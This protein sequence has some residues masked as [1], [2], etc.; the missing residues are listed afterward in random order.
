M[1][2]DVEN[3]WFYKLCK[4]SCTKDVALITV[5]IAIAVIALVLMKWVI[6]TIQILMIIG[7][8]VL[9]VGGFSAFFK[10][11][12][13]VKRFLRF[14]SP[15]QFDSLGT[16]PPSPWYGQMYMTKHFLCIPEEYVMI[17]Y[18]DITDIQIVRNLSDN[19]VSGYTVSLSVQGRKDAVNI[20]VS[21]WQNFEIT[22][23]SFFGE[24][25]EHRTAAVQ[26]V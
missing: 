6:S 18:M 15:E 21:D 12:P 9:V 20:V 13:A 11:L 2:N 8:V 17:P 19:K 5:G 14:M 1:Q 16:Q 24:L 7:G 3:C 23:E 25:Q 10:K 4:K 22:K 26:N